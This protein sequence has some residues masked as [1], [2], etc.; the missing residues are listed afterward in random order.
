MPVSDHQTVS[1]DGA[2]ICDMTTGRFKIARYE[3]MGVDAVLADTTHSFGRHIHNQFGLGIILRGAQKSLSGRGVVEASAGDVITV[4]PD[5]VHDGSPVGDQGRSWKMLYFDQAALN[6]AINDLT[7]GR[8]TA[9]ELSYPVINDRVA[10]KRFLELFQTVINSSGVSSQGAD[11]EIE[12]REHLLILLSRLFDHLPCEGMGSIPATMELVRTRIDDAPADN[13]LLE[14]LAVLAGVS[15]FQLIRGFKRL[16][17]LTPHAYLVPRRL[18]HARIMISKGITLSE[19]AYAAGFA[20][21]SHMTRLFVRA[22]GFSPG[23]YARAV[24]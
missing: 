8:I 15:Q 13:V 3:T 7:E 17:G 21:Q 20:D 10:A 11:S 4:N 2:V 9:G 16:T 22:Y 24:V 6:A 23:N 19:C 5:E 14:E 1:F 12:M 18:H